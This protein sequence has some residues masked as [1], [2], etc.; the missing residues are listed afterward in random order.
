M[1]QELKDLR[2]ERDGSLRKLEQETRR[3]DKFR[4]IIRGMQQQGRTV[5][6]AAHAAIESA[7]RQENGESDYSGDEDEERDEDDDEELNGSHGS[8]D[9]DE[10]E[11]SGNSE[12]DR[13]PIPIRAPLKEPGPPARKIVRGCPRRPAQ[14]QPTTNGH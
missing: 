14:P 5:T 11:S 6:P 13:R 12:D 2:T 9:S 3:A 7:M 1:A 10:D 8:D 4:D